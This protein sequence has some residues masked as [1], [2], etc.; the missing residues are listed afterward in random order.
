M[1]LQLP[2]QGVKYTKRG[3]FRCFYRKLSPHGHDDVYA[4]R[5]AVDALMSLFS[6]ARVE[7]RQLGRADGR[8]GHFGFFRERHVALW[9]SV[10]DFLDEHVAAGAARGAD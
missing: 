1:P 8:F 2:C 7:R 10:A 6:T 5:A 4:P 9:R 3:Y